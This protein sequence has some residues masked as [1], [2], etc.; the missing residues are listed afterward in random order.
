MAIYTPLQLK[1][2][3]IYLCL[4]LLAYIR[5]RLPQ[6]TLLLASYHAASLYTIFTYCMH[7]PFALFSMD[8]DEHSF[9]LFSTSR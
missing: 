2:T 9:L 4:K 8:F 5:R 1:Q 7:L 6:P 3:D